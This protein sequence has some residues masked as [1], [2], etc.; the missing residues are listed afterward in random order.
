MKIQNKLTL[1]FTLLIT[2]VLVCIN[3]YIY[4][5]FL[6]YTKNEFYSDLKERANIA[7]VVF[8]EADERSNSALEAYRKKY[9]HALPLEVIRIFNDQNKP[10]MVNAPDG[11]AYDTAVI[12]EVR[13]NGEIRLEEK[14]KQTVGI[15]YRDNEGNFVI[16]VTAFNDDGKKAIENLQRVLLTGFILSV[17]IIFFTGRYFTRQMLVPIAHI[18]GQAN[19]I[20]ETNL[21]LRLQEGNR[22]DEIAQLSITINKMLDRLEHAFDLQKSFV[23]N[24][25]HELRT[26]LTSIIGNIDVTLSRPRD[27]KE[28]RQV[29]N[30]I[31]AEAEKLRDLTNGLLS[32]AQSNMDLPD[33]KE[34]IR[35]DEVLLSAKDQLRSKQYKNIVSMD[36]GALPEDATWLVIHGNRKLLETAILNILDNA[37]KFSEGKEVKVKLSADVNKIDVLV[38]DLGIGISP[39]DIPHLTETFYRATNASQF[40]GSGIGLALTDRIIQLYGGNLSIESQLDKGTKVRIEFVRNA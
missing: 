40:L 21:H 16:L 24:A 31:L 13:N 9:S 34:E 5:E 37:C 3:L 2:L 7:A 19:R 33:V 27:E 15:Y 39:E 38:E 8:L 4:F 12:N 30:E 20:S 1:L 26:P 11:I 29:L 18:S 36:F 25:S 17:V 23:S 6:T 10:V 35:I 28:Y 14:A 32:L 22:K